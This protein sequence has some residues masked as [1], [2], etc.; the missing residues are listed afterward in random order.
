MVLTLNTARLEGDL[1][2]FSDTG[3]K[4]VAEFPGP[5]DTSA[6]GPVRDKPVCLGNGLGEV[7]ERRLLRALLA[8]VGLGL[9]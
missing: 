7:S 4:T 9:L 8:Q 5:P 6:V 3:H 1:I 2:F